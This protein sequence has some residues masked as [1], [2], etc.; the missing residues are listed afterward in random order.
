[1]ASRSDQLTLLE[2]AGFGE[3]DEVDVTG[4]YLETARAWLRES[5]RFEHELRQVL[6]NDEFDRLQRERPVTISAIEDGLLRR[7]LLVGTKPR[8]HL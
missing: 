6:G 5:W 8:A 1:M 7:S 2:R 4:E 3:V